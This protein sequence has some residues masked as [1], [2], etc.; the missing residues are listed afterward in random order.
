MPEGEGRYNNI[1]VFR[2][3]LVTLMTA[4]NFDE[5]LTAFP[6]R[7]PFRPFTVVFSSGTLFEVDHP[8]AL[9]FRD[10]VALFVRPGGVP[11]IFDREGVEHFI[12]EQT[13]S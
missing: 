11:V 6:Q 5:T 13:L 10:G 3:R 9:V 12:G 4:H 8:S 7:K 2:S 1:L